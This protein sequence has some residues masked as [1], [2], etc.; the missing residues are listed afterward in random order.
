[1]ITMAKKII[2]AYGIKVNGELKYVGS[3]DDCIKRKSCHLANL[4]KNKHKNRSLQADY[5]LQ[6]ESAFSFEILEECLIKDLFLVEIKYMELYPDIFNKRTIK[7]TEKNIRRG[8]EAANYK[9]KRSEVTSGENNGHCQTTIEQIKE[10]KRLIVS[11]L[12][13]KDIAEL[14]DK[15]PTYISR[16]RTGDRWKSVEV[17]E[18][19]A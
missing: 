6:G 19:E 4:R 8:R 1:M 14:T 18:V 17:E 15:S 5:N 9:Q 10:I 3:A 16:I 12:K 13:N 7:N 11:G 2:G